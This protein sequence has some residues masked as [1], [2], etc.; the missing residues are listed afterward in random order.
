MLVSLYWRRLFFILRSRCQDPELAADLT[1][2][3]FLTVIRAARNGS[4]DN[5][6]A[7]GAYIKSTGI[8]LLITHYRKEQRRKTEADENIDQVFA[9]VR[10][11]LHQ[12]LSTEQ[13]VAIVRQLMAEMTSERDKQLL[14]QYFVQG[15][16][17]T[18]ICEQFD[19]P[20]AHFDRVLFRARQR[21]K[22]MLQT[23]LNLDID[24]VGLSHILLLL[25][26]MMQIPSPAVPPYLN[27]Q[28]WL[29]EIQATTHPIAM[30]V[31]DDGIFYSGALWYQ[32]GGQQHASN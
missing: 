25:L 19:L 9:D 4:I 11:D 22:Q 24:K 12:Q 29:R 10:S 13:L 15:C 26:A 17:K 1:Q 23:R 6:K 30:P 28:Y 31:R 3:T 20:P 2:D 7:L 16:D 8:S 5:P 18:Q 27:S 32:P 21:L 14:I